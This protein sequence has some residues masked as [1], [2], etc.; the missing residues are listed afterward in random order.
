M[1]TGTKYNEI[2]IL[3]QVTYHMWGS[4]YCIVYCVVIY[5]SL[6]HCVLYCIVLSEVRA[7][8]VVLYFSASCEFTS[9]CVAFVMDT[10]GTCFLKRKCTPMGDDWFGAVTYRKK[11][12]IPYLYPSPLFPPSSISHLC[13]TLWKSKNPRC[14]CPCYSY[15]SVFFPRYATPEIIP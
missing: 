4:L 11:S 8:C 1:Q 10:F 9:G 14:L 3:G 6:R 7:S 13:Q 5:C 12:K 15:I 2:P